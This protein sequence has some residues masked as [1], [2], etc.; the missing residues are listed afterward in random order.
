[1]WG[2]GLK[3]QGESKHQGRQGFREAEVGEVAPLSC[4]MVRPPDML[5]R[6]TCTGAAAVRRAIWRRAVRAAMVAVVRV[7]IW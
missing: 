7:L 4:W 1:M 3:I 5:R 6:V 2:L